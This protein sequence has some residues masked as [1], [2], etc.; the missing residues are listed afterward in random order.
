MNALSGMYRAATVATLGFLIALPNVRAQAPEAGSPPAGKLF[1]T[2]LDG[3]GALND[4]HQRTAREPIVEVDDENHRPVA[5]ALVLFTLPGTGP[6]GAFADGAQ[7]LSA[8]TD[9]AGRAVAH[10]LQHNS[11]QGSYNIEVKATYNGQTAQTT[12]HQKNVNGQ[13]SAAQ[14]AA[15]GATVKVVLA[16]VGAAAVA[17]TVAGILLTRGGNSTTITP[18]TPTVGAPGA[19]PGLRFALHRRGH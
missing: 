9:S 15:H 5:G 6:S 12:I 11:V 14:H 10:G 2:I 13:S 1:I 8:V 16:V 19:T 7:T 3:E 4:I 18:G 17:G